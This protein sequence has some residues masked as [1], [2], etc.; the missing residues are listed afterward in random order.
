MHSIEQKISKQGR[1]F[2]M[3]KYIIQLETNF[4][5]FYYNVYIF[6]AMKF[7]LSTMDITC[8]LFNILH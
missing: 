7:Y 8:L 3:F 2:K 5:I 1:K 4:K 6:N